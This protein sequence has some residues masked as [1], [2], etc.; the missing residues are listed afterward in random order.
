VVRLAE[1]SAIQNADVR[2]A[3]GL[4]RVESL[5]PLDRLV[6]QGRLVR[7]GERRGTRYRCP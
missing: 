1:A 3:T 5:A 4:D 7:S 2:R 6:A